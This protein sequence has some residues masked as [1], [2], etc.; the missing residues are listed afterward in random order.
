MRLIP[1]ALLVVLST[2]LVHA[3]ERSEPFLQRGKV[4][5]DSARTIAD[6]ADRA[7]RPAERHVLLGRAMQVNA[8]A[9]DLAMAACRVMTAD[10]RAKVLAFQRNVYALDARILK[11]RAQYRATTDIV[12]QRVKRYRATPTIIRQAARLDQLQK[13]RARATVTR[14]NTARQI[15]RAELNKWRFTRIA[16]RLR[17]GNK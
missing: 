1:A 17:N 4:A 12:V 9:R 2:S 16:A 14:A 13:Q 7:R 3:A 8:R 15:R 5:F 10:N 6:K 11:G